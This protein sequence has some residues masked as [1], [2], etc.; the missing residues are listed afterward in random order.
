M[1]KKP[2]R[3]VLYRETHGGPETFFTDCPD[4]VAYS[5]TEECKSDRVYE[6]TSGR[7]PFHYAPEV[8]DALLGDGPIGR[9]GD[10]PGLENKVAEALGVEPPHDLPRGPELAVDNDE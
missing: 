5:I 1:S 2:Y 9:F 7:G 8:I 4:L 10:R 6:I 3:V